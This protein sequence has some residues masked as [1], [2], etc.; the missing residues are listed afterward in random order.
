MFKNAESDDETKYDTFY[1]H[2]KAKAVINESDTDDVFES[3]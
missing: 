2:S 1:S 3:I